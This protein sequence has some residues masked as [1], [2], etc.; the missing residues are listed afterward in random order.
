MRGGGRVVEI[1]WR[2]E[3]LTWSV[4]SGRSGV[5]AFSARRMSIA[6]GSRKRSSLVQ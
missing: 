4:V 1:G 3:D 2:G 6:V 5:L